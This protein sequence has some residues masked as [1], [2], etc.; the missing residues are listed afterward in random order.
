M[1]SFEF[2][3]PKFPTNPPTPPTPPTN[4]LFVAKPSLLTD[5]L[6]KRKLSNQAEVYSKVGKNRG[7]VDASFESM[8]RKE[9][10][11]QD[12][13]PWCAYYIKLVLLQLYSFDR[14]WISKNITGSAYGNLQTVIALN[15]KGDK[16]YIAT[17]NPNELPQIGDVFC[18]G[19]QGDGH[20]GIVIEILDGT[21]VKTIEGNTSLKGVREGEGVFTLTRDI[22]IGNKSGSKI[23]KGYFRRNFTEE[24]KKMLEFD[25][26][27]QT[28]IFKQADKS[29]FGNIFNFGK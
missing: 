6:N 13:Q 24:E 28:F 2:T 22:K 9:V 18:Q 17:T 20:T 11:W 26:Q 19:V 15:R 25:D 14:Q 12:G 8:M 5:F 1:P 23:V 21:K 3:P 7:F 10:D 16:R 4:P 27:N 29:L